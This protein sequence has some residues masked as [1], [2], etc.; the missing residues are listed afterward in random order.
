MKKLVART[1]M[2]L[3]LGVLM[4]GSSALAQ[5]VERVIQANIPFDFNVGSQTFPAGNYSLVSSAPALLALRDDTGHTLV[6][7]LTNAVETLN[8]PASPT[9]QFNS[10]DGR[11]SLAQ[12]WQQNYSIGQQLQMPKAWT[13]IA[14]GRPVHIQTVTARNAQ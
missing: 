12:V 1:L 5:R 2:F 3:L 13:K 4:F 7:V 11:F 14:K 10:V 8:T 9:L 6:K